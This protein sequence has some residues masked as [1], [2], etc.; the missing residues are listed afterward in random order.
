M[1]VNGLNRCFTELATLF[2]QFGT[3]LKFCVSRFFRPKNIFFEIS[4]IFTPFFQFNHVHATVS[5]C[6]FQFGCTLFSEEALRTICFSIFVTNPLFFR[7]LERKTD[8]RIGVLTCL[9]IY[10]LVVLLSTTQWKIARFLAL[11]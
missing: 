8:F 6:K 7:S 1:P 5:T 4:P 10:Q 2:T 3:N 9:S 11:H